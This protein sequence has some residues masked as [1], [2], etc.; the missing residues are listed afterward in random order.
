MCLFLMQLWDLKGKYCRNTMFGH[1][2]SVNH[3]RFS[4]NDEY[5][6]SCSTDGTVKVHSMFVKSA[7]WFDLFFIKCKI[8]IRKFCICIISFLWIKLWNS[9]VLLLFLMLNF[10]KACLLPEKK[11]G[12]YCLK[13]I[14]PS[15]ILNPLHHFFWKM[16]VAKKM[17]GGCFKTYLNKKCWCVYIYICKSF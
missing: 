2:N 17:G 16:Y 12:V 15:F 6:A 13:Q 8:C 11:F 3:C 14:L 4:P 1:V 10:E 5:V 7:A 9:W